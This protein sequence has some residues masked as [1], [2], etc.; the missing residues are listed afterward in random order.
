MANLLKNLIVPGEELHGPRARFGA[1]FSGCL[2]L[3]LA[4]LLRQSTQVR[5]LP[6]LEFV[7]IALFG[8]FAWGQAVD[9]SLESR[10]ET[11]GDEENRP[12]SPTSNTPDAELQAHRATFLQK[13]I[14]ANTYI[15]ADNIRL[16]YRFAYS[17][18]ELA[19]NQLLDS[20]DTDVVTEVLKLAVVGTWWAEPEYSLET[21]D[22]S[23]ENG[24]PCLP[25]EQ[26]S[27]HEIYLAFKD[28]LHLDEAVEPELFVIKQHVAQ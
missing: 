24:V 9:D 10:I 21:I 17:C 2:I 25:Q 8:V 18:K 26:A 5:F 7:A 19:E 6:T 22:T 15:F 11:T 4:V 23:D 27:S 13:L 3:H 16:D 12:H 14:V 28:D 1:A 20:V